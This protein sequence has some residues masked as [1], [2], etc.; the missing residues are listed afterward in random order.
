MNINATVGIFYSGQARTFRSCWPNHWWYVLRHFPEAKVF[1]SVADDAQARDMELLRQRF[2]KA[3]IEVVKQPDFAEAEKYET[4]NAWGGY[5]LSAKAANVLKAFWHYEK[6]W[7]MKGGEVFDINVRIRPDLWFQEMELPGHVEAWECWTAPWGSWGGIND[8]FA[9]MG[10]KAAESYM[11]AH[12]GMM[13]LL[14]AGAPFHPETLTRAAV[15]RNGGKCVQRL[16][17][18][19]KI[20]RLAD[21]EHYFKEWLVDEPFLDSEVYRAVLHK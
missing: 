12:S 17:A 6:V 20:R 21:Q 7:K 18:T 15:E 4:M 5:P 9:I 3:K 16:A 2:P 1:A 11:T 10:A 8:R 13:G 19:F 14:E